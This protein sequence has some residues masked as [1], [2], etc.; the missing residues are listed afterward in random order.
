[1]HLKQVTARHSALDAESIKYNHLLIRWLRKNLNQVQ[2]AMTNWR[3]LPIVHKQFY[4]KMNL[5]SYNY[6][7]NW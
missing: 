2:D 3:N 1:M 5:R 6:A 4:P 7:L